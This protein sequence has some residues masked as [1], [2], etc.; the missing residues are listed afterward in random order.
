MEKAG[1]RVK[2]SP[3]S[4]Q[5]GEAVLRLYYAGIKSQK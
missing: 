4:E 3:L 1:V 2:L 5:H